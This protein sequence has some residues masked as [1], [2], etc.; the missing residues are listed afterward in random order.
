MAIIKNVYQTNF[1]GPLFGT[2]SNPDFDAAAG[3]NLPLGSVPDEFEAWN[4]TQMTTPTDE[5][6]YYFRWQ[7]TMAYTFCI[8][9]TYSSTL[10]REDSYITTGGVSTFVTSDALKWVPNLS[11]MIATGST[12]LTITGISNA[13]QAVV[14]AANNFTAADQGVTW[15]T[16]HGVV[17]MDQINTL[18]GQ[19][20]TATSGASFIVNI[21]TT[22]MGTYSSGGQ[23][24]VITG[25]PVTTQFGPQVIMTPQRDLGLAG[26]TLGVN[27]FA[28]GADNDVWIFEAKWNGPVEG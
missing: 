18:R 27:L 22:N 19:V 12:N 17:G 3:M 11:A 7:S 14:T 9:A 2:F 8:I 13:A 16:F 21:D 5:A 15:V 24:N 26:L 6:V 4:I 25:A 28:G 10:T 20:V 1:S 23:A